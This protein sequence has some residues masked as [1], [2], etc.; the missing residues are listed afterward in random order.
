MANS[1]DGHGGQQVFTRMVM[2]SSVDSTGRTN[3]IRPYFFNTWFMDFFFKI[4]S[5]E[6]KK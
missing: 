1:V 3:S 6:G 5:E 2:I 4:M